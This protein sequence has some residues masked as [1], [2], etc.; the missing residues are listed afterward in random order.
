MIPD[1]AY[2]FFWHCMYTLPTLCKK[3]VVQFLYCIFSYTMM[4]ILYFLTMLVIVMVVID[5]SLFNIQINRS[6]VVLISNQFVICKQAYLI[7]GMLVQ[8]E[9]CKSNI[10]DLSV[11]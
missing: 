10:S 7:V 5:L 1:M 6:L 11:V 9:S 4:L 3:H 8:F 2:I